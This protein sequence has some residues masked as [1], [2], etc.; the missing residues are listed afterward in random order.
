MKLL[1]SD[2]FVAVVV[3]A[4]AA[5]A[6]FMNHA[7]N[8]IWRR[9]IRVCMGFSTRYPGRSLKVK[10]FN[11]NGLPY[12][13]RVLFT[14]GFV[15]LPIYLDLSDFLESWFSLHKEE[16]RQNTPVRTACRTK[17]KIPG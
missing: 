10:I 14:P 11:K 8:P 1:L 12:S 17:S 6:L 2:A 13:L 15:I 16:T 9:I 4:Q 5:Q 3:V 7:R